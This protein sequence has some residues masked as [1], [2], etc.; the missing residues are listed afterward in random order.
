MGLGWLFG[1]KK[2]KVPLPESKPFDESTFQFSKKF[3]GETIIEPE[4][5]QKA[6]GY[7]EQ[8]HI[9]E[10]AAAKNKP[11]SAVLPPPVARPS[12]LAKSCPTQA[13]FVKVEVYQ[14][15]L[16]KLDECKQNIATLQGACRGLENSEYNEEHLFE[17][18]KS[19]VKSVHDK[20]LS[21]DKVLFKCLGE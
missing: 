4:S 2:P 18:M 15:M 7:G 20:L 11:K 19:S 3:G 12:M 13:V 8:F 17:N 10:E 21:V 14:Q 5:L 1:K 9:P 16:D 6:A